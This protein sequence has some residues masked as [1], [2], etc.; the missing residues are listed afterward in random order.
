MQTQVSVKHLLLDFIYLG[1]QLK[2]LFKEREEYHAIIEFVTAKDYLD[3]ELDIPLPRMKELEEATKIKMHTL[4]K[5]LLKMHSEIFNFDGR[6]SLSYKK[7]IYHFHVSFLDN[8]RCQFTVDHL[9]HLPKVGEQIS[10]PFIKASLPVNYFHVEN[11]N[12]ELEN[13]IQI[14]TITVKSGSYSE[15]YNFMKDRALELGEI[16]FI[17][18]YKLREDEIK[19]I[20]YTKA[21]YR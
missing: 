21:P 18:I 6:Y 4:R 16:S 9:V 7:V 15:Y 13:D 14:I 20:I 10:L 1:N 3:D 17:Q 19:K 12:H 2:V 11:I 8:Y 5:L